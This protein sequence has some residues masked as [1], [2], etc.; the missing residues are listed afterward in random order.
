MLESLTRWQ[1]KEI[2]E[3]IVQQ[4]Q[5][6]LSISEVTARLLVS[7]GI[8]SVESAKNFLH[9]DSTPYFDPFLLKDMERAV[10]RIHTAIEKQETILIFGDYDADGVTSTSLLVYTFRKLHAKF[11][12][13]I[14]NRFTEGYGP[15]EAAFRWA[16]QQGVSLIVTV[17]T[18]ISAVYEAEV[19]KELQLDLIITDH[20]E[21]PLTLPDA[22][23]IINPKQPDCSYP[24]N[25]LAGVG[26]AFKLAQALVGT[27]PKE[28]LDLV[29]IG[30][31]SDL[32]PLIEENR[33]FVFEG[34]PLIENSDK[35]GIQALLA[36]CGLNGKPLDEEQIGFLLGPRLNAA[37]RMDSADPALQL[38]IAMNEDDAN[39]WA[40]QL[41]ELNKERQKLVDAMAKQAIDLVEEKYKNDR[42]IVIS[43]EGWNSGV[44]GIVASRLVERYY[45]PV[46]ALA[47]ELESGE[48]KGSARSIAHFDLYAN[49]SLCEDILVNFG[50]H[51]MAAGL[52]INVN[53]IDELRQRLNVIAQ[54]QLTGDDFIPITEIDVECNVEDVTIE[55]LEEI[56]QL[57][58]FGVGNPKPKVLLENKQLSHVR[59]IG[60]QE[61]HLK[62][63]LKENEAVLEG[64]G[65]RFGHLFHEVTQNVS[66]SLVGELSINEWNGFR[67]PQVILSDL[68]VQNWQLFDYR[69]VKQV[70]EHLK[71]L[72]AEDVQLIYFRNETIDALQLYHWEQVAYCPIT[73]NGSF[74]LNRPYHVILD[75]PRQENELSDWYASIAKQP[76]RTYAFFHHAEDHL[77]TPI[78]SREQ[79]KLFYALMKKVQQTTVEKAFRL[80]RSY[81]LRDDS[82][83]FITKVFNELNFVKINEG[84]LSFVNNPEKKALT[85]SKTYQHKLAMIE[86]EKKLLYSSYDE[87]KSFFQNIYDRLQVEE[88]IK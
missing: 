38:L 42:V 61:N 46:V 11:L 23:A 80:A 54:E 9:I 43:H 26:V 72:R 28:L 2:D 79:F 52:T 53:Q 15:N 75:L 84:N 13:Y 82:I 78:P 25:E 70:A 10:K 16:K 66:V 45:R 12:T 44:I 88:A 40:E 34:I 24:F 83:H 36:S 73:N 7:R 3:A 6:K 1:V 65:F 81:R 69:G 76:K 55:T 30:T 31:V 22:F 68:S 21:P 19:A 39:A 51:T 87:L 67:K 50:G 64:V 35:P 47:I 18:G 56:A 86:I 59:K 85:D 32:V 37:G 49:L 60:S 57:A 14:P 58:P 20:H 71:R 17:D 74:D 63:Q 48:A 8:E 77:F 29:A 27:V 62:F 4:I 41:N 5:N 33:K